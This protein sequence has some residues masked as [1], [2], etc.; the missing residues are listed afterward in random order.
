MDIALSEAWQTWTP[1]RLRPSV[2]PG[3]KRHR[4]PEFMSFLTWAQQTISFSLVRYEIS[5]FVRG[6]FRVDMRR[7]IS[8]SS[9]S[10]P[11]ARSRSRFMD[12]D[13]CPF[14]GSTFSPPRSLQH[15]QA[16]SL[17]SSAVLRDSMCWVPETGDRDSRDSWLSSN[18][19][20]WACLSSQRSAAVLVLLPGSRKG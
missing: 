5:T 1:L 11:D 12:S 9:M 13:S 18:T 10:M 17:Y 4:R 16:G 3:L 19:P 20:R 8:S 6:L 7:E 2:V 14:Q 15:R